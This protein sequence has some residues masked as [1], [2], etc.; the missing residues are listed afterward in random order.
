MKEK[1]KQLSYTKVVVEEDTENPVPI[2]IITEDEKMISTMRQLEGIRSP[3]TGKHAAGSID[4]KD[5]KLI[6]FLIRVAMTLDGSSYYSFS[7]LTE[8]PFLFPFKYRVTKE[9]LMQDDHFTLSTFD[10]ALSVA[11]KE[12]K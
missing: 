2:A 5:E 3:Q 12:T 11:L 4:V 10:A 6:S 8:F 1:P 7:S 9:Q